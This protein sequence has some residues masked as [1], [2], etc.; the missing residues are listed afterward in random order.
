MEILED[1]QAK[2]KL[3]L[4][5][6]MAKEIFG[7]IHL[8]LRDDFIASDQL[9]DYFKGA[10]CLLLEQTA[11]PLNMHTIVGKIFQKHQLAYPNPL[12]FADTNWVKDYFAFIV[13]PAN[14]QLELWRVGESG[15]EGS[16]MSMW[17]QWLN[18]TRKDIPWSVY[19]KPYEYSP[20]VI[21][22]NLFI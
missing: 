10:L 3:K 18:G 1:F 16:P 5:L 2:T 15:L 20:E 13:S 19:H 14:N 7:K 11:F 8:H 17:Q 6:E 12:I 22:R 21:Q 9:Q 4:N